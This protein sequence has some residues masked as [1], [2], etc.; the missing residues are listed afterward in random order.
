[1]LKRASPVFASSLSELTAEIPLIHIDAEGRTID[2]L[3]QYIYPDCRPEVG[4]D[5]DAFLA[6][7]QLAVVYQVGHVMQI[8]RK[9]L[10]TPEMLTQFPIR[11]YAAATRWRFTA[12]AEIA[13]E[14]TGRLDLARASEKEVGNISATDLVKLMGR[15][16]RRKSDIL[17]ALK[18]WKSSLCKTC[19]SMPGDSW[20]MRY[21][22]RAVDEVKKHPATD[23]IFSEEFIN[24]ETGKSNCPEC[25]NYFVLSQRLKDLKQAAAHSMRRQSPSYSRKSVQSTV[26]TIAP[27]TPIPST[28][29]LEN[30]FSEG[31]CILRSIDS[32]DIRVYRRILIEASMFWKHLFSLPQSQPDVDP[33]DPESAV[34]IVDCTERGRTLKLLLQLIYPVPKPKFRTFAQIEPVLEAAHKFEM[35]AALQHLAGILRE[36]HFIQLDPVRVYALACR[37]DLPE[38][39]RLSSSFTL[40]SDLEQT[41]EESVFGLS[42]ISFLRLLQF[43]DTRAAQITAILTERAPPSP[44][45][46]CKIA[47]ASNWLRLALEEVCRRPVSDTIFGL[48]FVTKSFDVEQV[49]RSFDR[50]GYHQCNNIFNIA[51]HDWLQELKK[52]ID[53]LPESLDP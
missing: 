3:L 27:I 11:I 20:S 49:R 48:S 50:I 26:S 31:D 44:C 5:F 24:Q 16:V 38:L 28:P 15:H 8:L 2:M 7:L 14:A 40:R 6:V 10:V 43:R 37:Y 32:Q 22:V 25:D 23:V 39:A 53:M 47:W 29:Q 21:Y 34:P 33:A 12:E 18:G 30:I 36:A 52:K 4:S 9:M 51:D 41:A 13:A 35:D 45:E 1:M 19:Q 42:A 46:Q 17:E